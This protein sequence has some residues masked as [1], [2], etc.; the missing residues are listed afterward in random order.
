MVVAGSVAGGGFC[1]RWRDLRCGLS[2]SFWLLGREPLGE[3]P[4]ELPLG[5]LF[6]W[7]SGDMIEVWAWLEA[8]E[9]ER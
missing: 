8:E 3:L 2:R 7:S 9:M 1:G 4:R 5:K 6:Q